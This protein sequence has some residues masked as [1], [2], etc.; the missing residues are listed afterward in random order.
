[1]ELFF[2]DLSEDVV[3]EGSFQSTRQLTEAIVGYLAER[4]LNPVR[5][6]WR[7]QGAVILEKI[8]RARQKLAENT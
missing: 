1:V 4:N 8:Q 2:R 7:A 5:Y 3:R 6:E